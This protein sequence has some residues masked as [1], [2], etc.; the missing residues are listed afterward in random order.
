MV[1]AVTKGVLASLAIII[2]ASIIAWVLYNEFVERL[3]EYERPPLA[4][5]LGLGPVMIGVGILWG[6]QCLR[7]FADRGRGDGC[8]LQP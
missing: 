7:Y 6:R 2:G 5:P 1:S 8:D 3:P 4:G